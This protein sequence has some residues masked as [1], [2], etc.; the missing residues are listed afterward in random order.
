MDL[1]NQCVYIFKVKFDSVNHFF[2]SCF[3]GEI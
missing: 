2:N 3:S 1:K